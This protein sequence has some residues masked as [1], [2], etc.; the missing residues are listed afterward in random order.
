MDR[1]RSLLRSLPDAPRLQRQPKL[2]ELDENT[3][4]VTIL[5]GG[6]TPKTAGNTRRADLPY[7]ESQIVSVVFIDAATKKPTEAPGLKLG[8]MRPP[9]LYR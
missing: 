5:F 2:H 3:E 6:G 4:V 1:Q 7:E 8:P 9:E